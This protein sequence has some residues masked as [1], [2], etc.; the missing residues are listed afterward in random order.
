MCFKFEAHHCNL[1]YGKNRGSG[2]KLD[3]LEEINV[4]A[5][6]EVK[7][8]LFHMAVDIQKNVFIVLKSKSAKSSRF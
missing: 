6:T 7:C 3:K 8:N 1:A 4:D 2:F 5:V